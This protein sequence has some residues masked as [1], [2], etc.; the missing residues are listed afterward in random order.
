M[1]YNEPHP[2]ET[3]IISKRFCLPNSASISTY[4]ANEGYDAIKKAMGMTPDAI[5]DELK[6]SNLRGRGGAGFPTGLKWS[7]V[8]RTSPKPKYIIVNADESEPGTCKDR[9]LMEFDPHSLLEGMMI[10]GF[11]MGAKYGWIYIRGEYRYLIDIMDKAIAEAYERGLLGDKILGTDFSFHIR[12]H[13][14]AGAY[15]CGE[16]SALLESFEGKRGIPRI[17]PPFPAVSGAYQSP[18]LLNNVETFCTVP[19]I[20]LMGGAAY[21]ALGIPKS[22]GTKMLCISGHVNKPGVYEVPL[23]FPMM[24]AI[25]ELAGGMRNGKKLKAVVPGGSSCPMLTAA[26]CDGLTLDY[27]ALAKV[28]SM[29]GSGGMIVLDEDTDMVRVALRIMRFYQHESCGWCIPCREGTTWLKKLLTRFVEGAGS[30]SDIIMIGDLAKN[31]LGRTFCP[32]GDAAA[33]PTISIIEKFRHEFEDYL[34][35]GPKPRRN[36]LERSNGPWPGHQETVD[37][38]NLTL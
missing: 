26:E 14:G 7:F 1:P 37:A 12:T 34:V 9:L 29:L 10:G 31:M 27:D 20:L 15:E 36:Y 4:L 28:K 17:R 33:M 3:R 16:E 22:G 38:V 18:T 19:P 23:G 21:A 24:R 13:T 25:E 11:V 30:Q 5:I 32:L 6:A 35:H 2:A 8:P